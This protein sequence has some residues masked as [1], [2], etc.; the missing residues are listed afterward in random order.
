MYDL[1][2]ATSQQDY[3]DRMLDTALYALECAWHPHFKG[4][5]A[6]G[7]ARL[8]YDEGENALFFGAC[9]RCIRGLAKRGMHRTALE[10]CKLVLGVDHGDPSGVLF[11]MDYFCIRSRQCAPPSRLSAIVG[12]FCVTLCGACL[13]AAASLGAG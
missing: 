8:L 7:T 9:G 12:A 1:Y 5:L 3:G 6:G 4:H 10:W 2:I 13:I 11:H